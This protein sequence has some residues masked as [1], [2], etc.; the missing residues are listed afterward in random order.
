M[1][2]EYGEGLFEVELNDACEGAEYPE[3]FAKQLYKGLTA[4]VGA[5]EY[6]SY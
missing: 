2:V 1:D 6:S 4:T 5:H 3:E